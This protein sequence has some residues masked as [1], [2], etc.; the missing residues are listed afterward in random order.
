MTYQYTVKSVN[1]LCKQHMWG[2]NTLEELNSA[3]KIH[4]NDASSEGYHNYQILKNE[5][6]I[7]VLS[8]KNILPVLN[9]L[10]DT[11][12]YS[13]RNNMF[14]KVQVHRKFSYQSYYYS[15]KDEAYLCLKELAKF[16]AKSPYPEEN[17]QYIDEHIMYVVLKED[18]AFPKNPCITFSRE[19]LL[20]LIG[21]YVNPMPFSLQ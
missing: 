10:P 7:G 19:D 1:D 2:C 12:S 20:E 17:Y 6:L 3:L 5:K 13:S 8:F 4:L 11:A 18:R 14:F 21:L 9:L 16:I 15:S